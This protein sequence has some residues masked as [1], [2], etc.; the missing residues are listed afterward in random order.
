MGKPLEI[1]ET[2]FDEV[3]LRSENPV[4]IDFWGAGCK[5]CLAITPVIDELAEDFD[6]RISFIKIN[7][8]ECPTIAG[9]YGVMGL[10][11]LLIFKGGRPVDSI[12]GIKSKDEL[13]KRLENA[14]SS[15]T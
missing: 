10:P 4:L 1:G 12:S 15:V 8:E 5:P 9:R 3:V 7:V 11:T 6:G 2:E 14:L 13:E